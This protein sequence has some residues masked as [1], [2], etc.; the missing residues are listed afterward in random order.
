MLKKGNN[1]NSHLSIFKA[2]KIDSMIF[3]SAL[4]NI[5]VVYHQ[6]LSLAGN[7][8]FVCAVTKTAMRQPNMTAAW[9]LSP[10]DFP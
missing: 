7:F 6:I 2:H 8:S 10:S 9:P 5:G 3:N 1:N 4:L